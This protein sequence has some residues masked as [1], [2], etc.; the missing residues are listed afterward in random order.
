M[1]RVVR[2]T[3]PSA[4]FEVE[5]PAATAFVRGTT[6]RVEVAPSGAT[7][8]QNVPD[9]TDG[10]VTV[11]AKD[12]AGGQ[13][14]LQPGQ[15]TAVLP[16]L[17]P[18]PPGPITQLPF[19]GEVFQTSQQQ[20]QNQATERQE[21]RQFEQ[22]R[23][24]E[25]A[26]QAQAALVAAELEMRRLVEQERRLVQEVAMLL[27]PG[28]GGGGG[29]GG[30]VSGN[31]RQHI[32]STLTPDGSGPCATQIGQ[33]CQVGGDLSG[34]QGT[35]TASMSW[36]ILVPANRIPPG[37]IATVFIPT[38]VGI[39]F[40]DCPPPTTGQ[41]TVCTGVTIGNGRL[42]GTVRVFA[43]NAQ[44]AQGSILGQAG[45]SPTATH[46]ATGVVV[47]NTPTPTP[48]PVMS[49]CQP[50]GTICRVLVPAG[51]PG[52]TVT[53]TI[54]IG[55]PCS[56]LELTSGGGCIQFQSTGAQDNLS[57][58]ING[59]TPGAGQALLS[60]PAR[61]QFGNPV[62]ITNLPCTLQSPPGR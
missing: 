54:V 31:N 16:G 13:V 32:A 24:Q 2:L 9:G 14:T 4:T 19:L 47:T 8:V 42:G 17:P 51:G 34:S 5:T 36:R 43:N 57:G 7:R 41:A 15:Q 26:A 53:G 59:V 1:N 27:T 49:P 10:V 18:S 45:V 52:S 20:V 38:T 11:T 61:D 46:I 25:A 22:V 40:F 48:L 44:I 29:G 35:V 55:A 33:V 23:A 39:E 56:V 6:P 60:F 62:T 12:P 28:T 37:A 3:D 30:G 58:Q 50:P 21:Q